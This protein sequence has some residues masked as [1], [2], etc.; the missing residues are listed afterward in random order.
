MAHTTTLIALWEKNLL[1]EFRSVMVNHLVHKGVIITLKYKC[2][3]TNVLMFFILFF[4]FNGAAY[5]NVL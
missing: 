1:K 5:D 4:I 2:T 3:D